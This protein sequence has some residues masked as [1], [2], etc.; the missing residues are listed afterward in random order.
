MKTIGWLL[1]LVG[2]AALPLLAQDPV[3][4]SPEHYKVQID[5]EYVR[6]VRATRGPG[7]KAPMHE[8]PDYVAVYL[9]NVDQKITSPDGKVQ[10]VHRKKNEVSFSKA[11]KHAEENI[12][13]APLEVLVVE[14]KPG[15]VPST[16]PWGG[17]DPLK[18]DPQHHKLEFENDRIRVIRSVREPGAKI[19]MHEHRKYVTIALTD[20]NSKQTMPDGTTAMNRRKAGEVAW[21]EPVKHAVENVGNDRM[22]E[23]QIEFK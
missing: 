23:I 6:V 12:A 17:V 8:H 9:T 1:S 7:E 19:P 18:V 20:V 16:S 15:P 3:K 11:L 13:D 2:M 4:V 22:E 21:R 5:N 14:L 10:E